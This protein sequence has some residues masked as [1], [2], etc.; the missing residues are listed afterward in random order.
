MRVEGWYRQEG[1]VRLSRRGKRGGGRSGER[2]KWEKTNEEYKD[3]Y[4]SDVLFPSS[5]GN[6]WFGTPALH[7]CVTIVR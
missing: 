1:I 6:F 2:G 5:P 4:H 7:V 3:K